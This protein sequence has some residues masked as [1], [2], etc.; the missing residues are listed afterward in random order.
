MWM[1]AACHALAD[2]PPRHPLELPP[3]DRTVLDIRLVDSLEAPDPHGHL[4]DE[5]L[6]AELRRRIESIDQG[7]AAAVPWHEGSH[8]SSARSTTL[9]I[10]DYSE[11]AMGISGSRRVARRQS[12]RSSPW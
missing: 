7:G 12:S 10:I 11:G 1:P 5:G 6:A 9:T 3:E 4:T 8:S 2:R